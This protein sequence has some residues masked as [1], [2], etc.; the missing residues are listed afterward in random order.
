[1]FGIWASLI[2]LKADREGSSSLRDL[3]LDRSKVPN[4]K[5]NN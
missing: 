2:D 3:L 1:V 4:P 5:T